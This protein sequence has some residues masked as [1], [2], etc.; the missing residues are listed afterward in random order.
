MAD[1][2]QLLPGGT[3]DGRA[4]VVRGERRGGEPDLGWSRFVTRTVAVV[5]V[6]ADHLAIVR[7][8]AVAAV[9]QYVG[10]ALR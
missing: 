10:D 7:K 6:P 1:E 2:Y 3:F 5:E 4:L 9:G 8:P